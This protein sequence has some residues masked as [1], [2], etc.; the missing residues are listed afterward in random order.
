MEEFSIYLKKI[1]LKRDKTYFYFSYDKI[2][3]FFKVLIY[4]IMVI[5]MSFK[6]IYHDLSLYNYLWLKGERLELK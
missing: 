2:F 6:I 4:N 1:I 3:I 5:I